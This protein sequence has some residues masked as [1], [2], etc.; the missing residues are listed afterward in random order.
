VI[1]D[2]Q[3]QDQ[4]PTATE[5][6]LAAFQ[7][8]AEFVWLDELLAQRPEPSVS[9]PVESSGAGWDAVVLRALWWSLSGLLVVGL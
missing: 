1:H 3:S 8:A 2:D 7:E 5:L 9:P 6:L 4:E